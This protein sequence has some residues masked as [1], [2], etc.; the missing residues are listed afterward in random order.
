MKKLKESYK[1]SLSKEEVK[2]NRIKKLI[3]EL[4]EIR[5]I[6]NRLPYISTSEAELYFIS[7]DSSFVDVSIYAKKKSERKY[8]NEVGK[9]KG[10]RVVLKDEQRETTTK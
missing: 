4:V 10:R 9:W 8:L 2:N 6:S 3:L 7:S 5:R 1:L